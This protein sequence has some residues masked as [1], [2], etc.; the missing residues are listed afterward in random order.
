M[1]KL[2]QIITEES[3]SIV[4]GYRQIVQ[5]MT[6]IGL[7]WCE[8]NADDMCGDQSLYLWSYDVMNSS[9]DSFIND[10]LLNYII[11]FHTF[12]QFK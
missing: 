4:R 9:L 12:M 8:S 3:V 1:W 5:V 2:S 7:Q 6:G 11:D 10:K